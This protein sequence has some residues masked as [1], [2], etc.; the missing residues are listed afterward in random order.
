MSSKYVY[1]QVSKDEYQ[2][3]LA[4]ADSAVEL[5][6][7]CGTNPNCIHSSICHAEK[8]KNHRISYIRVKVDEQEGRGT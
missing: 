6:R 5:A 3:P 8:K 2:L 1:M 4:I 7:I